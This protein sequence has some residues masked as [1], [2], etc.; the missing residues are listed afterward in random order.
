MLFLEA[1][2]SLTLWK[3]IIHIFPLKCFAGLLGTPQVETPG[4]RIPDPRIRELVRALA[5]SRKY[6]PWEWKCMAEAI[7]V[8]RMLQRRNIPATLYLGLHKKGKKELIAHAWL[9]CGDQIITGRRGI[10]KFRV[11]STFATGI[12]R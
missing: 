10:E 4:I 6:A 2:F 3:I 11:I 7:A 8:Q 9:R 5:R 1:G 12:S